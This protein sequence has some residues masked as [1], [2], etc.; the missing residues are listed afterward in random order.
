MLEFKTKEGK[1]M[2]LIVI[3]NGFDIHCGLKTSYPDFFR[4]RL[5]SEEYQNAVALL[6]DYK[7]DVFATQTDR[8]KELATNLLNSHFTIW[9]LFFLTIAHSLY[10]SD[11]YSDY[12]S[13]IKNWSDVED[14]IHSSFAHYG[15]EHKFPRWDVCFNSLLDPSDD[16]EKTTNSFRVLPYVLENTAGLKNELSNIKWSKNCFFEFLLNQLKDF[17]GFFR[18]FILEQ[19]D[20]NTDFQNKASQL[21]LS[22]G[23]DNNPQTQIESFNYTK[24]DKYPQMI[25]LH[26][27]TGGPNYPFFGVGSQGETFEMVSQGVRPFSDDFKPE[28]PRYLFTK[29]ARRLSSLLSGGQ[30][31][32]VDSILTEAVIYGHSLDAQDYPYFF[33]LFNALQLTNKKAKTK[34]TFAYSLFGSSPRDQIIEEKQKAIIKMFSAYEKFISWRPENSLF[35]D[36]EISGRLLCFCVK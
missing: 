27:V 23:G 26:G 5:K 21:I 4:E 22:L 3:G 9:D 16:E 15:E 11:D 30:S 35:S 20:Q 12:L 19:T 10:S 13:T 1:V 2:K 36:L 18:D 24:L 17:E 28:E 33:Q 29:E 34:I 31:R 32:N 25:N 14:L 7:P 8:V 6:K